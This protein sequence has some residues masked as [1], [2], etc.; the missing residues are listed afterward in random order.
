MSSRLLTWTPTPPLTM[1]AA[2]WVAVTSLTPH[3]SASPTKAAT[4]RF[5]PFGSL[6]LSAPPP[7]EH[8][9]FQ[10]SIWTLVYLSFFAIFVYDCMFQESKNPSLLLGGCSGRTVRTLPSNKCRTTGSFYLPHRSLLRSGY[11]CFLPTQFLPTF[12][13]YLPFDML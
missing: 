6:G 10:V 4:S 1:V 9:N 2:V 11:G 3:A 5:L 8:L 13:F 12:K 7:S